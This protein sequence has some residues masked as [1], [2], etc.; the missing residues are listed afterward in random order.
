VVVDST[1]CLGVVSFDPASVPSIGEGDVAT[2]SAVVE[3]CGS[4]SATVHVRDAR[5]GAHLG[6]AYVVWPDACFP[7]LADESSETIELT[8]W[9]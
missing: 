4:A 2:V 3:S 8:V 5:S 9:E 6:T 7:A 1:I